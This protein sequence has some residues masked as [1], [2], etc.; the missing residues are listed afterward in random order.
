MV[1][2]R[3][4]NLQSKQCKYAYILG[5]FDLKAARLSRSDRSVALECVPRERFE[6]IRNRLY[7]LHTQT[8]PKPRYFRQYR[9]PGQDASG[10]NGTYGHPNLH[11]RLNFSWHMIS[12]WGE[13]ATD[14]HNKRDLRKKD[15]TQRTKQSVAGNVR[16][17]YHG[18]AETDCFSSEMAGTEAQPKLMHALAAVPRSVVCH[19]TSRAE[20]R[21]G[22]VHEAGRDVL[23]HLSGHDA[24]RRAFGR[25]EGTSRHTQHTGQHWCQPGTYCQVLH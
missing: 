3:R 13:H 22:W 23:P 4:W 11:S 25:Q 8:K 2:V 7:G 5:V 17:S 6:S 16:S 1:C 14:S 15:D 20:H 19:V 9:N 24:G 10:K 18:C 12:T 21:P